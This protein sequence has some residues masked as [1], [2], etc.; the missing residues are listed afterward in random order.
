M[1]PEE[2]IAMPRSKASAHVEPVGAP[3]VNGM[4]GPVETTQW[5]FI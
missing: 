2:S 1:E 5:H 3:V 4:V